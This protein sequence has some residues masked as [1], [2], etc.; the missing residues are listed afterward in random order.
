VS[1]EKYLLTQN[2][3]CFKIKQINVLKSN[4]FQILILLLNFRQTIVAA[5]EQNNWLFE[6]TR[7]VE[8]E[9]MTREFLAIP[10]SL[11][12]QTDATVSN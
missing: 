4:T 6:A 2:Y 5:R 1:P 8:V 12:D 9:S 7:P 11:Q 3:I 10:P